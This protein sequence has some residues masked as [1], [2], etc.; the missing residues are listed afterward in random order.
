G[1]GRPARASASSATTPARYP[2]CT[3]TA[4]AAPASASPGVARARLPLWSPGDAAQ[5]P[6]PRPARHHR[7]QLGTSVA[8]RPADRRLAGRHRRGTADLRMAGADLRVRGRAGAAGRV[9]LR[10]A[11]RNRRAGTGTGGGV[12]HGR[13]VAGP[14]AGVDGSDP[15]P[16]SLWSLD[17]E[18][19]V[20]VGS[21]AKTVAPGLRLGFLTA[22]AP[23]VRRLVERGYVH[24]G[25][26][27]NHATAFA[28]AVLGRSGRYAAHVEAVRDRYRRQRDALVG[29]LHGGALDVGALDV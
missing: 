18:T 9:A 20:R 11:R 8:R 14:R 3:T 23:F 16:E 17:P 15:A 21:F 28:M 24:S 13:R 1:C 27:L 6:V 7:P 12:R 25:G 22:A 19:V 5:Y 26:G 29:A 2:S 10:A 4:T